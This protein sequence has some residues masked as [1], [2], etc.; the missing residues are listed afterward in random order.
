MCDICESKEVLINVELVDEAPIIWCGSISVK[1]L[2]YSDFGVFVDRG[3]IRFCDM[4]DCGCMDHGQKVKINFC[5]NC[6]KDLTSI[7]I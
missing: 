2:T 3:H 1:D 7:S 6:G 5:P 4:S